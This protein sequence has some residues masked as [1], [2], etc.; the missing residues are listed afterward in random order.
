MSIWIFDPG[1]EGMSPG[2]IYL[3]KGK[4]SPLV[5]PGIY[6]GEFNHDI[7]NRVCTACT[8]A[9]IDCV[10]ISPGPISI[11]LKNS[12]H[13]ERSRVGYVNKLHEELGDCVLVSVHSN[14]T[15]KGNWDES[16]SGMTSF[17]SP[18]AG[19][20]S[21]MLVEIF[22]NALVKMTSLKDR[23]IRKQTFATIDQT[24]MPA[25]YL[26]IGFMT[27]PK[28]ARFLASPEGRNKIVQAMLASIF[29]WECIIL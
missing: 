14:A 12:K 26:E 4:Q 2:D 25:I 3:R 20:Q 17:V 19:Y 7:V 16:A 28:D 15:G 6:E 9:G 13:P 11:A 23:G 22:H 18:K 21:K 5:P 8:A 27:H 24:T 10:N 29:E 1:H